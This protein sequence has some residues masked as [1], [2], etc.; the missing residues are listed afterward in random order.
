MCDEGRIR[1]DAAS[2][3]IRINDD[4]DTEKIVVYPKSIA[5]YVP[6]SKSE[7]YIT[8]SDKGVNEGT[9]FNSNNLIGT[10]TLTA[11]SKISLYNRHFSGTIRAYKA[12]GTVGGTVYVDLKYYVM[13]GS[14]QVKMGTITVLAV[15]ESGELNI[16]GGSELIIGRNLPAGT[17][18]IYITHQPVTYQGQ[19]ISIV[20]SDIA[21]SCRYVVT[22]YIEPKTVVGI[23]GVVSAKD[24]EQYFVDD[25]SGERQKII[26]CGLQTEKSANMSEG[27]LYVSGNFIEAFKSFL[28]ELDSVFDDVRFVGNNKEYARNISAKIS[29]LKSNLTDTALIASS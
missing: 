3:G 25:N 22:P 13:R 10:V 29:S 8:T 6:H 5:P 4:N 23:D 2:G 27:E 18:N 7:G 15:T 12:G 9:T 11:A 14:T 28:D 16:V 24:G 21:F 17:Y 19:N 20:S 1:I 26:A